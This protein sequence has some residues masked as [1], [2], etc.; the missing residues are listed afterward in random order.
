MPRSSVPPPDLPF[1]DEV[2]HALVRRRDTGRRDGHRIALVIGGGGMRG[3]YAGGMTHAIHDLELGRH[4]DVIYGSSAGAYIGAGLLI[5]KGPGTAQIF[6]ED[7]ASPAFI[8]HRRLRSRQPM[9]D[10]DHLLDAIMV[11]SKPMDWPALRDSKVPLRVVATAVDDLSG[12]VLQPRTAAEW[13]LALRATSTIPWLA[14]RPVR[15]HG[16]RWIDG[17]VAEP[18]PLERALRDGATHVLALVNRTVVELRRATPQ[19]RASGWARTLDRFIPG[20]GSMAQ[21]TRRHGPV[22]ALLDAPKD[23]APHTAHL[24]VVTPQQDAGVSGLTTDPARVEEAARIGYATFRAAADR[25]IAAS[26]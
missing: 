14:G 8:D 16:R 22:M 18:L 21:E 17:S 23:T 19:R 20:L 2:I 5:G 12:H 11:D 10:L 1:D 4:F 26:A 7:M 6:Y 15:L 24:A 25:V 9:I 13:K 3:A